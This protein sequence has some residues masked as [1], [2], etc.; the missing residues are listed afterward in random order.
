VAP[1]EAPDNAMPASQLI[2]KGFARGTSTNNLVVV[3]F[4][5]RRRSEGAADDEE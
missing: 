5:G 4:G 3:P 1:Q 2:S